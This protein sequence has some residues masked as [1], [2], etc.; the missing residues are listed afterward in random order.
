MVGVNPYSNP[1]ERYD[2]FLLPFCT[3]DH[4]KLNNVTNTTSSTETNFITKLLS[5]DSSKFQDSGYFVQVP[6]SSDNE[7]TQQQQQQQCTTDPLTKEQAE[8][9]KYAI[10]N[11]WFYEGNI[12]GLPIWGMIGEMIPPPTTTYYHHHHLNK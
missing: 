10:E 2:Y 7:N 11:R 4:N 5:L 12:D 9:L 3:P 1:H 6:A 8:Q